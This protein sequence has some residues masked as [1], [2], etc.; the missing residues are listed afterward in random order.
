MDL[1]RIKERGR[2][3]TPL[4]WLTNP[5]RWLLWKLAIPYYEGFA[6]EIAVDQKS[7]LTT[8]ISESQHDLMKQLPDMVLPQLQATLGPRLLESLL[9]VLAQ[10][11]EA[12][13]VE[14]AAKLAV[15]RLA[16]LDAERLE[17]L[18]NARMN[19]AR[20]DMVALSHRLSGIESECAG[21]SRAISAIRDAHASAEAR[22]KSEARDVFAFTQA[23]QIEKNTEVTSLRDALNG[24]SAQLAESLVQQGALAQKVELLAASGRP[25]RAGD[26][27]DIG[28]GNLLLVATA[29]GDRLLVRSQDLIGRIVAD[30]QEWEPH[31]RKAIEQAARAEGIAVD[32]GAYIGLH[33]VTMS[34]LFSRVHA[35]EPQQG[36][37]KVLCGNLALNGCANVTTHNLALYDEVGEMQ[38]APLE[39]Q[40]VSVP[41]AGADPDY[42]LISNAAA[43]T[44]EIASD[45]AGTIR[46]MKLDDFALEDVS[47]IKVDTQG[48]DLHVLRGAEATIRRCQPVILFEWERDLDE[49]HATTLE[50]FF[51]FFSS[52]DYAVSMLHET[53][54]GRQADYIAV[55][56]RLT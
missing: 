48:S 11:L 23:L 38:L 10:Q 30:G 25:L 49:Q 7:G 6:S 12:P 5:V 54:A 20:K 8:G 55:P 46:S 14:H 45:G 32:A 29:R 28:A 31:V 27:V 39:R 18:V 47:L 44:Y 52:H 22:S 24:L 37:F 35:F 50:D 15:E 17:V 3:R 40:E 41:M 56:S 36:I 33:S 19:G 13:I 4:G 9:P 43:L 34:R 26:R 21:S 53:L 51:A 42:S 1:G 16:P 2:S